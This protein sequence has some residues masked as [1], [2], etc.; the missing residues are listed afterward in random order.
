MPPI[1]QGKFMMAPQDDVPPITALLAGFAGGMRLNSLDLKV[2]AAGQRCLLDWLGCVIAGNADPFQRPLLEYARKCGGAPEA[3]L[4]GTGEPGG[5]EIA[6][7]VNG[8]AAHLHDYD[9]TYLRMYGHPS[10]APIAAAFAAAE[11]SGCDGS[12]LLAAVVGGVEITCRLGRMLG[13]EAYQHGFTPASQTGVFGAAA[14][15]CI[16][17][18]VPE[19][20]I[21]TALGLAGAMA[22]GLHCNGM[23]SAGLVQIGAAAAS[24]VRCVDLAQF[25]ASAN[26]SV[27]ECRSGYAQSRTQAP[28]WD[29]TIGDQNAHYEM[30][31]I[32]FKFHAACGGAQA[33]IA[34]S[35]AHAAR[36]SFDSDALSA[37][38]VV[39][40]PGVKRLCRI[41]TPR[42]GA[43]AKLSLPFAVAAGL[44]GIDTSSIAAYSE[45]S[46]DLPV[47]RRLMAM[48]EVRA[49]DDIP[50][51]ETSVTLRDRSGRAV[52]EEA[53][54]DSLERD[55]AKLWRMLADKFGKLVGP[56]IG[57]ERAGKIIDAVAQRRSAREIAVLACARPA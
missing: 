10:A 53:R 9:D 54:A 45:H 39:V 26:P 17:A 40:S 48:T 15:A 23:Y 50:E 14:A 52:T 18:G 47:I 33:A 38:D 2:V 46:I 55:D 7:L 42:S 22:S 57:D 16:A 20:H 29:A 28:I 19:D 49:S 27:I 31:D 41:H 37:I 56:V 24:G 1:G 34:A 3:S 30:L 6:A 4:L 21:H 32:M 8:S 11:R 51:W 35:A 36:P 13:Y 25:G 43:E 44:A 5:A 12:D